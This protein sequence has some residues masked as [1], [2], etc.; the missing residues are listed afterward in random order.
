[1]DNTYRWVVCID[2]NAQSLEESYGHVYNLMKEL[3]KDSKNLTYEDWESTDEVYD[4]EGGQ[5]DPDVI[6]K[7]RE[8]FLSKVEEIEEI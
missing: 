7:A 2:I 6:Q 1:M 3:K 4:P 8:S 5:I